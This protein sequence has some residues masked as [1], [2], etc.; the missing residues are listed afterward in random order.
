[1]KKAGRGKQVV[2]NAEEFYAGNCRFEYILQRAIEDSL[3]ETIGES[4]ALATRICLDTSVALEDPI[5]YVAVLR[6]LLGNRATGVIR[7]IERKLQAISALR[8][9]GVACFCESI[10]YLNRLYSAETLARWK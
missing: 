9:A 5:T 8:S 10:M 2:Q 4:L 1:M 7:R 3:N 6:I